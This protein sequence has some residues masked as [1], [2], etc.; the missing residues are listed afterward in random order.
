MPGTSGDFALLRLKSSVP[1]SKSIS[2]ICL[3]NNSEENF[4]NEVGTAI[5]WGQTEQGDVSSVLR[6]V[7]HTYI[8]NPK[9][10]YILANW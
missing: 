6:E 7:I 9:N 3:P 2:P 5:G 4:M 8:V 10:L 1:F